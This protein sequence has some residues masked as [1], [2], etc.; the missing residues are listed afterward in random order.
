MELG[1]MLRARRFLRNFC[2]NEKGSVAT[3]FALALIP[4]MTAVGAAVDYSRANAA[5]THLQAALDSALIAGAKD[6]TSNWLQV[7]QKVFTANIASKNIS[8]STPT[9]TSESD[10]SYAGSVSASVPTTVLGVIS[11]RTLTVGAYSKAQMVEADD[12]CILTL[13][14]GQPSS[15]QSLTLNGAPVVNLSGC[16]I[17]SNTSMDCN[18]HDGSATKSYA[19]G[20]ATGCAAPKSNV[21]IVP[22]TYASL[23]SNIT[24]QCGT[25]RPG[26]S[27][28]PGTLPTVG[29]N[30]IRVDKGSYTEYHVCGDLTV[31]G[32][33]YLTGNPPAKDTVVIIEN[34]SLTVANNADLNTVKTTIVMTGDNNYSSNINFPNGTGKLGTLT[35]SAST[36]STN[37]WQ[38]V[39]MYLD[40]SLTKD[41]DNSWGSGA[42]FNAEGLVYLGNSNVVTYGN[43][44]SSNSKCTKFVMNSLTTNGHVDLN[45][46]QA[47]C[48][49]IGLKQ[50]GGITVHLTR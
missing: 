16:S 11:I 1:I 12:S 20:V 43:M 19:S 50:W 29:T 44:A 36:G 38:G 46:T 40:P 25:S 30:F 3:I 31:S 39:A 41:V 37:P 9:F 26:L 22:D 45:F 33:G 4:V 7:A 24:K 49:A 14:H 47:D 8:A 5:R 32:S 17:R 23:A 13:D 18:G 35:L 15:H 10:S 2:R 28:N 48:A 42:E 21:T 27:W 34:G 6:D